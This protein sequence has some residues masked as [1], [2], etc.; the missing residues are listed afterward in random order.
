MLL[1]E[2]IAQFLH[3]AKVEK[4]FSANSIL[5]YGRDITRFVGFL[6]LGNAAKSAHLTKDHT[7][8]YIVHLS[9][10]ELSARTQARHLS[11]IRQ[12]ARFLIRDAHGHRKQKKQSSDRRW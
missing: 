12:F 10:Q 4:G 8:A 7:K 1:A 2:A 11:V 5:A 6:A 9:K 3:Y